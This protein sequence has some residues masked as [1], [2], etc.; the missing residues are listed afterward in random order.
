MKLLV[1]VGQFF[2]LRQLCQG[3]EIVPGGPA[4]H[5]ERL[6]V[7]RRRRGQ[8]R[9][10]RSLKMCRHETGQG[11]QKIRG[12]RERPVCWSFRGRLIIERKIVEIHSRE[13]K[14]KDQE[15]RAECSISAV[16]VG[17]QSVSV[18]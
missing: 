4:G 2:L 10:K 1:G 7:T 12:K 18:G 9:K 14:L 6:A 17:V 13:V 16:R 5:D 15:A 11:R 8:R 3:Q